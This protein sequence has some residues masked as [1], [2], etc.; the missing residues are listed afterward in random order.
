ANTASGMVVHDERTL[1]YT[2][3][4]AKRTFRYIIFKIEEKQKEVIVEKR[5]AR[6]VGSFSLPGSNSNLLYTSI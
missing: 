4:K 5:T 3:L 6:R 2:E 1:K